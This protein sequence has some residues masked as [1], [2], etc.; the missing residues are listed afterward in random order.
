MASVSRVEYMKEYYKK[1]YQKN[2]EKISQKEREYREANKEKIAET[3]KEYE[4][5][6]KK[7]IAETKKIYRQTE[8]YKK[9]SRIRGWK[10]RGVLSNNFDELYD[11]YINIP[12]CE[13]CNIELI[14]GDLFSNKKC[15]DHDHETGQFRN[16]LC[17]PCNLKRR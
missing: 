12:N 17:Y 7:K 6:N 2:K 13:I 9:S 5:K 16:I 11:T 3:H 8:K 1:Y 10:Y 14:E 15:L 4:Q